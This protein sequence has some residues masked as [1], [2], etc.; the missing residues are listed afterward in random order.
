MLF[1]LSEWGEYIFSIRYMSHIIISYRA[2]NIL[3]D[4]LDIFVQKVNMT[5]K[6]QIHKL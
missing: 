1:V 3:Q 4:A 2:S 5:R 6:C